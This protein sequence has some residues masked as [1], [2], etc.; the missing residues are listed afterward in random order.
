MNQPHPE[1]LSSSLKPRKIVVPLAEGLRWRGGGGFIYQEKMDGCFSTLATGGHVLAGERMKD[2]RFFAFDCLAVDGQ[3]IRHRTTR[4]RL[5]A[6]RG[7]FQESK[8]LAPINP[9]GRLPLI[10]FSSGAPAR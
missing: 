9:G 6:L 3:D 5:N 7:W 4:E 2:G 1:F 8:N 10:W